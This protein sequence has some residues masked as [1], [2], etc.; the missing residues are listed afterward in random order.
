MQY[1]YS[2]LEK[3]QYKEINKGCKWSQITMTS[4]PMESMCVYISDHNCN[5]LP[6]N[7]V[8]TGH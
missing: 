1:T 7:D 3:E 5:F 2:M 6:D 4:M 8:L